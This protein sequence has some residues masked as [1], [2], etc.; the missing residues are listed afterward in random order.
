MTGHTPQDDPPSPGS[1]Q[2]GDA[3]PEAHVS[4][5]AQAG[6]SVPDQSEP[7]AG[8]AEPRAVA[9]A[10]IWPRVVGVLVLLLGAGGAWLWQN[11]G[12]V[13]DTMASLFPDSASDVSSINALEARVTRLEQR[14]MP[15]DPGPLTRRLDALENRAPLLQAGQ[16]SVDLRPMLARLDA[17]EARAKEEA[18]SRSAGSGAAGGVA[19]APRAAAVPDLGPLIARLD[20]LE[21]SVADRTVA[22]GKIDALASRVEALSARDP[23]TELRSRLD[24]VDQKLN[25][26]AAGGAKLA[27]ASDHTARV[28]RLQS[29]AMALAAGQALGPFPDAPPALAKFATAAPPTEAALRL[30]FPAASQAALRV[31]QPDTEGKP[32]LDRI[33]ARLQDIRL[34]TVR[35]GDR[36]VIGNQA[37]AIL[38]EAQSLLE[39]GDLAGA[40]RVVA[41]L[42]GPPAEKMA[43]WLADAKSLVAARE[44]LVS[45]AGSS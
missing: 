38:A 15:A 13:R 26:L 21:K 5:G 4:P 45:L 8:E 1:N 6:H 37:S 24:G 20:M 9:R 44:A 28:A 10:R 30:A 43:A 31:S 16:S 27:D 34:I 23:A 19:S 41:T 12:F 18:A 22:P 2:H 25:G 40:V 36:V 17:L 7:V 39:A 35:E 33:L 29:A 11:P 3:A 14:P 32:F 42:S